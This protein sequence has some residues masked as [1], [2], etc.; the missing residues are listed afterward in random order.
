MGPGNLS[1]RLSSPNTRQKIDLTPPII[2]V[3]CTR[4]VCIF[5][6]CFCSCR[7]CTR[8]VDLELPLDVEVGR[9]RLKGAGAYLASRQRAYLPRIG[10]SCFLS[11]LF[12]LSPAFPPPPIIT[13]VAR[14]FIAK[15][16]S[17]QGSLTASLVC[18]L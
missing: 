4:Y 11:L 16:I 8:H 13:L 10:R 5:F 15:A 18:L 7:D 3:N 14:G 17:S 12:C 2:R 1:L 9:G 6:F